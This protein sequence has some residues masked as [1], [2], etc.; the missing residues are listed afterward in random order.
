MA[1]DL[2][3]IGIKHG[4]LEPRNVMRLGGGFCLIDFS[5]SRKHNCKKKKV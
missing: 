2:H 1:Q 3:S 5:Q 4:D